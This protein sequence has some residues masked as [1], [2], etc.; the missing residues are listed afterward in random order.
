M[1]VE[2]EQADAGRDGRTCLA[3]PNSRA[4]T[5]TGIIFPCSA[6]HEQDSQP[7]PVDQYHGLGCSGWNKVG[8]YEGTSVE[9]REQVNIAASIPSVKE[10]ALELLIGVASVT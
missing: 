1:S 8:F 10:T 9:P 2:N 3:R 7:Y 4:R 5:G 6:D